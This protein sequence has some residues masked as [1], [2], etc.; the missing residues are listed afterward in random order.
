M[1]SRTI[2]LQTRYGMKV[3]EYYLIRLFW[4]TIILKTSSGIK[5]AVVLSL[6]K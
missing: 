6:L 4:H 3:I 5:G 2:L 1:L